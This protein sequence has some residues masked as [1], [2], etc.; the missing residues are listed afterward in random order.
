MHKEVIGEPCTVANAIEG[1]CDADRYAVCGNDEDAAIVFAGLTYDEMQELA[2]PVL[3]E[4]ANSKG[5]IT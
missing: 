5:I 4:Y 1:V 2:E 3:R